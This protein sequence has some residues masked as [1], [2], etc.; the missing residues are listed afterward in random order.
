MIV[1]LD[2]VLLKF[3]TKISVNYKFY[4]LIFTIFLNKRFFIHL[5]FELF[6]F[7]L[8]IKYFLQN[9]NFKLLN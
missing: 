4:F 7:I 9:L 8:R 6:L 5:S 2:F 3:E 1:Q